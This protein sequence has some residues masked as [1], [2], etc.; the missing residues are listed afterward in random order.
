MAPGKALIG[1]NATEK[2]SGTTVA[3][4]AGGRTLF[5]RRTDLAPDAPF[6]ETVAIDK[7]I[8]PTDLRITLTDAAGRELLAYSPWSAT[9]DK[10]LPEIVKRPLRPEQIENTEEC[11]LVGM[12]NLQFHNPFI[13]PT[14]YFEEVLRRDP[15]DTRANTQMGVWWR[16]RGVNEK[17][18]L[19]GASRSNARPRTIRV[20]R[21]ARRCTTWG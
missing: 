18:P 21:T 1:V 14:D 5:T 3:L 6:V 9:P 15:G 19:P 10:P 16:Q 13:D 2:L 17:P 12:R 8:R 11:Y 4:T 7:T 20:R